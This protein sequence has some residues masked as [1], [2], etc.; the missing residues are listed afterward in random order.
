M[1]SM[2]VAELELSPKQEAATRHLVVTPQDITAENDRML[3][4]LFKDAPK[5]EYPQLIQQ[6][7]LQQ[8][9]SQAEFNI[10]I[11][12]NAYLHKIGDPIVKSEITEDRLQESFKAI[13]GE[14]IVCRHIQLSNMEGVTE[15]K[16]RLANGEPFAQVAS[17]MSENTQ[18][19]PLGG[20]MPPFSRYATGYPDQFKE[21]A[22]ALKP[23]EVSDPVHVE[24][25]YHLIQLVKRIPP[26]VVKFEDVKETLRADLYDRLLEA[27]LKTM[28]QQM[29]DRITAT[30]QISDPVL[31]KAYDEKKSEADKEVHGKDN[32]RDAMKRD[33]IH[34]NAAAATQ[35]TN[36]AATQPAPQTQPAP[37]SKP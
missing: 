3:S 1:S 35:Q 27:R 21:V 16:R 8:H 20:E 10:F 24:G 9:I 30:M 19:K 4:A 17:E 11:E 37:T 25:F 2:N 32:I 15:A 7:L 29:V 34:T 23:G 14:T 18:T 33:E 28:R 22:F 36:P 6:L 13:Y 26:K 31:K 5:D 12:T